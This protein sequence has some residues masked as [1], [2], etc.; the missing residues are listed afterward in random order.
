[1]VYLPKTLFSVIVT[2]WLA[3]PVFG[4]ELCEPKEPLADLKKIAF[5]LNSD[6]SEILC[7]SQ[8]HRELEKL[9]PIT[10]GVFSAKGKMES[11][12]KQLE[13]LQN[14]KSNSSFKC[15]MGCSTQLAPQLEIKTYPTETQN[16]P[17]C[18]E[19]YKPLELTTEQV[20]S[21]SVL[22]KNKALVKAFSTKG[23]LKKCQDLASQFAQETLMSKN[24]LGKYIETEHCKSPCS[25]AS[26]IKVKTLENEAENC[27]VALEL[28]IECGPPRKAMEWKTTASLEK[29]FSCEADK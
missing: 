16:N 20:K 10:Y 25:Y 18:P 7:K 22:F 24:D 8:K 14:Q 11:L 13:D 3:N 21:Y 29:N 4:Q 9:G 6:N 26:S 15:P 2:L 23:D 12:F 27:R 19:S 5:K 1:M 28:S 17:A